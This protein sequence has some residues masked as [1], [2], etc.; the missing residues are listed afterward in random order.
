MKRSVQ[1]YLALFF[2]KTSTF[3]LRFVDGQTATVLGSRCTNTVMNPAVASPMT[4]VTELTS[5]ITV[6][7][8]GLAAF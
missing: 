2:S 6:I 5:S 7:V 8:G 3:P 1:T 4:A